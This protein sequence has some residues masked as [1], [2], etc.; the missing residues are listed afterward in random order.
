MLGLDL[1]RG[2]Y[3]WKKTYMI[4]IYLLDTHCMI[5]VA[6]ICMLLCPRAVVSTSFQF[7]Q[8]NEAKRS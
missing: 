5:H 4:L 6:E 2:F 1:P 3:A 7:P 8:A